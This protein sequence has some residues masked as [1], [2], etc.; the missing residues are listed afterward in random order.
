MA[1]TREEFEEMREEFASLRRRLADPAG[2]S[3]NPLSGPRVSAEDKSF[4][5]EVQKASAAVG[6]SFG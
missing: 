5:I 2:G 1:V 3:E 6:A 4:E